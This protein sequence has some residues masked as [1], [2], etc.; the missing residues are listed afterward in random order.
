MVSVVIFRREKGFAP[1]YLYILS[2]LLFFLIT[3]IIILSFFLIILII[4]DIGNYLV[5]LDL[6]AQ[7]PESR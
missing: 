7:S 3:L 4:L 5:Q 1:I 6:L 2:L